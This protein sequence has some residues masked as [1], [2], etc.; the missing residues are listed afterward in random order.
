MK[1]INFRGITES[2][3]DGEMKLVKG[4]NPV[5]FAIPGGDEPISDGSCSLKCFNNTTSCWVSACPGSI[6][7]AQDLCKSAECGGAY[8]S[9]S[10]T[11]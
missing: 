8:G 1:T 9:I 5:K 6:A 10:C 4:G 11:C 3:S 7:S 2:L